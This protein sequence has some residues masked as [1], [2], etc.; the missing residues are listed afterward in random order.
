[1][2]GPKGRLR[3][4]LQL[5]QQDGVGVFV[6]LFVV[7]CFLFFYLIFFCGEVAGVAGGYEE[8]GR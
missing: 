2:C 8:A 4:G 1:M 3:G 5:P 7:F 6:C